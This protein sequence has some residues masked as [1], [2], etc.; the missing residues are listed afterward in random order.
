MERLT[1]KRRGQNV[2]P[3]RQMSLEKN[4]EFS[5]VK[6]S[7]NVSFLYGDVT[8]KL[9]AYEDTGLTPE[10]VEEL[11]AFKAY[12]DDMYGKGLEIANWHLNGSLEPFDNFYDNACTKKKGK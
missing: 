9:S 11:K 2:I 6:V 8:N 5:L 7:D 4:F 12:F 1:E 10:E 3:L